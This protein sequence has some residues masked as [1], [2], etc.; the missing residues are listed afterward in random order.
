MAR[1]WEVVQR[2]DGQGVLAFLKNETPDA[3]IVDI[4]LPGADGRDICSRIRSISR[5]EQTG[6][7]LITPSVL[8]LGGPENLRATVQSTSADLVLPEPLGDKNIAGRLH[9]L[10]QE[11][12]RSSAGS[13]PGSSDAAAASSGA[14]SRGGFAEREAMGIASLEDE[15]RVLR[16]QVKAYQ[17]QQQTRPQECDSAVSA[18]GAAEQQRTLVAMQEQ[19]VSLQ[20]ELEV[21]KEAARSH[22]GE[23]ETLQSLLAERDSAIEDLECRLQSAEDEI[24]Q[25]RRAEAALQSDI[26][27]ARESMTQRN[28]EFEELKVQVSRLAGELEE[29]RS[30]LAALRQE[31]EATRAKSEQQAQE[32]GRRKENDSLLREYFRRILQAEHGE[33]L[34]DNDLLPQSAVSMGS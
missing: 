23:L 6:V 22:A 19:N 3:V 34:P 20:R 13:Q 10:F 21:Q 31:L 15:V 16:G 33:R 5:L 25:R 24:A 18:E 32:L 11:R 4:D 12:E 17:R 29:S 14:R 27:A 1:G 7:V 28:E 2:E 8:E 9:N 30:S 26:L